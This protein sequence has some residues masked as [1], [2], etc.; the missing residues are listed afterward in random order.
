MKGRKEERKKERERD[1][2]E[3]QKHGNS[4]DCELR[5]CCDDS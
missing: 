3:L 4:M 5:R 1:E 2:D